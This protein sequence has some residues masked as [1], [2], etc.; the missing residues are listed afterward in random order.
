MPRD[1][2]IR[3][4]DPATVAFLFL[5]EPQHV[6]HAA[7]VACV[8]AQVAPHLRPLFVVTGP[9]LVPLLRE[10]EAVYGV[11]E[12]LPVMV[13]EP[14]IWAR[15][16]GALVHRRR[17]YKALTLRRHRRVLDAMAAIVAAE[18]T[19]TVL[20]ALGVTRP[21]LIHIPHGAGDRQ[22]GFDPRVALFDLTIVAGRKDARRMLDEGL[23]RSG[24]YAVSGY[25]KRDLLQRRAELPQ[26]LFDNARPTVLYNAHFDRELSSWHR[27]AREIIAMFAAQD[28]FNLVVAPHVKLFVDASRRERARWQ[29]LEVPG[30]ISIDLGSRRSIDATYTS[31]C[32]LYL[33]DVSSQVYEFVLQPRPCVFLDSRGVGWQD[34]PNYAHWRMGEVVAAPEAVI[35]ALTR[36]SEV[37]AQ[38]RD[39][40][41]QAVAAALGPD[42][43]QAPQ[44][45]AAA[46]AEFLRDGRLPEPCDR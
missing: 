24:H 45:A 37:F 10:V 4:V 38:Y 17:S 31:A 5:G 28:R 35:P 39:V 41:V 26:A 30:K 8:L 44:R 9:T 42:A 21:R 13:L 15:V 25:I 19:S 16:L 27:H 36:A 3:H 2:R 34:D 11:V 20:R 32:D 46:I 22:Q 23:I 14:P 12:P 6:F 33:G 29:R 40:Q 43:N 7:P 1:E 18:R